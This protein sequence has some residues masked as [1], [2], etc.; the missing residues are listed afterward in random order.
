[1]GP[2]SL[3]E[4][5]LGSMSQPFGYTKFLLSSEHVLQ[6]HNVLLVLTTVFSGALQLL[7]E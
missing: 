1:M 3:M 2:A 4:L 7:M 6:V 5:F